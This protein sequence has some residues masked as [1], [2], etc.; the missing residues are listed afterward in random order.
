MFS[1]LFGVIVGGISALIYQQQM[2]RA[3]E[4]RDVQRGWDV[5]TA[6]GQRIG[7]VDEIRGEELLVWE[8]GPQGED[9]R[10]AAGCVRSARNGRVELTITRDELPQRAR[11]QMHRAA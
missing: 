10:I 3:P 5:F 11:V 1:F 9:Y 8:A 7:H 6:E 2:A 4:L